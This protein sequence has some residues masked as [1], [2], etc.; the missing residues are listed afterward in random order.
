MPSYLPGLQ[1]ADNRDLR[2]RMYR[3]NATRA[4]EFGEKRMRTTRR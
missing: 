2:A 1:Y 3:A 4:S